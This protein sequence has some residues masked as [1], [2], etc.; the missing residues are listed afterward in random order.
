M[1]GK[2]NCLWEKADVLVYGD[3]L[4]NEGK[5]H[6]FCQPRLSSNYQDWLVSKAMESLFDRS[7]IKNDL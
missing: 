5:R 3:V 2:R 4:V 7:I 1:F 6:N